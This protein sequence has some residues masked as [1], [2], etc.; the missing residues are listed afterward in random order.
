MN[1]NITFYA[2]ISVPAN[3][4]FGI[5]CFSRN[6]PVSSRNLLSGA[7]IFSHVMHVFRI[8]ATVKFGR[9]AEIP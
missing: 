8:K 6:F 3:V 5:N 7:Y 1:K 9:I 4:Y 2:C